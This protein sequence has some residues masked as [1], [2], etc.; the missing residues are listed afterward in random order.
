MLV[1]CIPNNK[2][3]SGHFP[4]AL[5]D[6]LDYLAIIKG[7]PHQTSTEPN[8]NALFLL[9]I[10]VNNFKYCFEAHMMQKLSSTTSELGHPIQYRKTKG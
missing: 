2:F 4:I 6:P 7:A 3:L 10:N 9:Q 1:S 5:L 8:V